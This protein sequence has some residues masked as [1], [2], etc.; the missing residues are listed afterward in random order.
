[1][2]FMRDKH[3]MIITTAIIRRIIGSNSSNKTAEVVIVESG[4][5]GCDE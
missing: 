2:Y 4:A 1:M 5:G 3:K